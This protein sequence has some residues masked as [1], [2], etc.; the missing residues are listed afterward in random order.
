MALP[1]VYHSNALCCDLMGGRFI[2]DTVVVPTLI[3][4][5]LDHRRFQ[6]VPGAR[7]GHQ[8]TGQRG[9]ESGGGGG[10]LDSGKTRQERQ[11]QD[12]L[13]RRTCPRGCRT[14]KASVNLPRDWNGS[15]GHHEVKM[16]Y[17]HS[18]IILPFN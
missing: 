4:N 11:N 9:G 18:C 16:G 8:D 10:G 7:C 17:F 15:V 1:P 12:E 5:E 2:P 6:S 13:E 3:T 14:Q